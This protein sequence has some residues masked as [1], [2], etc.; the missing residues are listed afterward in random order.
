[1]QKGGQMKSGLTNEI[2]YVLMVFSKGGLASYQ[3]FGA[4]GFQ[5][6]QP[7]ER[8][9]KYRWV[10]LSS[11]EPWGGLLLVNRIY[12]SKSMRKDGSREEEWYRTSY[13]QNWL[14]GLLCD[15]GR[16]IFQGT[17]KIVNL[18]GVEAPYKLNWKIRMERSRLC[19]ATNSGVILVDIKWLI[20][21][22]ESYH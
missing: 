13:L 7:S 14:L 3:N 8:L 22:S 2:Q 21:A 18:A 20:W 19:L 16:S 11:G 17:F 12:A 1:M 9:W 15:T 10:G 5:Q 4:L 6:N